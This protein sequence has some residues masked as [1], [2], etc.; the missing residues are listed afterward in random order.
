MHVGN[1]P[2]F[3]MA[4]GQQIYIYPSYNKDKGLKNVT[5]GNATDETVT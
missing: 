2:T 3:F 4:P 1:L 5:L